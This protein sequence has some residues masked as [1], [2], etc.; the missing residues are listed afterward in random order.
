LT[1]P[2]AVAGGVQS[3]FQVSVAKLV[4][5]MSWIELCVATLL[6]L[7]VAWKL[8]AWLDMLLAKR[9]VRIYPPRV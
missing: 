8:P 2:D 9:A 1:L 7:S 3:K 5:S 6:L 4:A